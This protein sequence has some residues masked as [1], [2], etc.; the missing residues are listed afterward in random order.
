VDARKHCAEKIF[1]PQREKLD[2]SKA[3]EIIW[4]CSMHVRDG[5]AIRNFSGIN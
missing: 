3:D 5:K 2:Q 1:G 4:V